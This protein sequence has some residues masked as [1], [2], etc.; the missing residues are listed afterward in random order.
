MNELDPGC[1]VVPYMLPGSTDAR[2]VIDQRI[3]TYGFAPVKPRKSIRELTS[4]VH[5]IDE[6][7][8]IGDVELSAEF[9]VRIIGKVC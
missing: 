4:R 6:R 9:A 8:G 1:E 3:P 2:F 7:I 5:G